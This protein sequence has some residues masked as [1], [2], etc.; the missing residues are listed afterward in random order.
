MR[1]SSN[2]ACKGCKADAAASAGA[3]ICGMADV[4][5]S[6]PWNRALWQSH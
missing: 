6:V 4:L 1:N 5:A 3:G 2:E